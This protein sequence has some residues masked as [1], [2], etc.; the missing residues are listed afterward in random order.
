MGRKVTHEHVYDINEAGKYR[1][2]V[3]YLAHGILELTFLAIELN[4]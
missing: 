2:E 3:Y 1:K 4:H